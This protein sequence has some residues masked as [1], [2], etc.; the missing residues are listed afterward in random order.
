MHMIN[1]I[2]VCFLFYEISYAVAFTYVLYKSYLFTRAIMVC[3]FDDMKTCWTIIKM[4]H[5]SFL[6]VLCS[7]KAEYM[8]ALF[9][10]VFVFQRMINFILDS[11]FWILF[12][13]KPAKRVKYLLRQIATFNTILFALKMN[14]TNKI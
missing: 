13:L 1:I 11:T 12:L 14:M 10:L 3:R 6:L 8:N 2:K 4:D 5:K 9:T 7:T